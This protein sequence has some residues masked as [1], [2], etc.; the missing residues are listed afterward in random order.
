[1]NTKPVPTP[2][3]LGESYANTTRDHLPNWLLDLIRDGVAQG[4]RSE[5]CWKVMIKL[6]QR[7]WSDAE[8]E[9]AFEA[10][11]IGEKMREQ[12]NAK[13]WFDYSMSKARLNA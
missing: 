10:G 12:R 2:R 13:K 11:G 6:V 8:I 4:E 7:G 5:A 3:P 1:M 9:S